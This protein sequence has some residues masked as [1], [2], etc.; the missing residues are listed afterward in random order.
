MV[1]TTGLLTDTRAQ[2]QTFLSTEL[3]Y[4]AAGDGTSTPVA[5]DTAL[6]NETFED[7]IDEVDTTLS[8]EITVTGI[9]GAGENN[10]SDIEE[11][12]LKDGAAGNLRAR[13]L[14]TTIT[15]TSD[16][17][18]YLDFTTTITVEEV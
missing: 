12:G 13:K 3:A 1:L 4:F 11:V 7:A 15:K 18:V 6:D 2:V 10:G 17:I 9:I 16:I 8:T 14:I 5:G